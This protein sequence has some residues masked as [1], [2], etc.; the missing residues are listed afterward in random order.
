[1]L[2]GGCARG[3]GLTPAGVNGCAL[4]GCWDYVLLGLAA[5]FSG[6]RQLHEAKSSLNASKYAA[7]V[8]SQCRLWIY[9]SLL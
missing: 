7:D 6:I 5:D 1:M 4:Q 9:F 3:A 2:H 8:A